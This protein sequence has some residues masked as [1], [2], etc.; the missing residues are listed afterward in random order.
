MLSSAA[1]FVK[2]QLQSI[3]VSPDSTIASEIA[4]RLEQD[5]RGGKI[6][7]RSWKNCSRAQLE[8]WVRSVE[9][10]VDVAI[11]GSHFQSRCDAWNDLPVLLGWTRGLE[12]SLWKEDGDQS[13][14]GA[15]FLA[16][17]TSFGGVLM[18]PS[19]TSSRKVAAWFQSAVSLFLPT[20]V[21]LLTFS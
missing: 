14:I 8:K 12:E 13:S 4:E 11:V 19:K 10:Q 1:G 18:Y 7:G 15:A 9:K 20:S 21:L 17:R 16:M 3:S 5:T 2:A 6:K